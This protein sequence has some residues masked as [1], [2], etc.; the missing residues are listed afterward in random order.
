MAA[1]TMSHLP[2]RLIGSIWEQML[3]T[4]KMSQY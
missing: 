1:L 4:F 2:I 3:L